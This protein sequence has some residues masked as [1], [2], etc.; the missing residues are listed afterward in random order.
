MKLLNCSLQEAEKKFAN[1]KIIFFGCGSWLQAINYTDLMSLKEQFAYIVDNN[2]H[3]EV[4]LGSM[5]LSVYSPKRIVA[6]QN[7][8]IVLTSPVYMYD[9]YCQLEEMNLSDE[10]ECYAFPFMQMISKQEINESLLNEIL[11]Y[12]KHKIPKIIHSFWFSGDEK[13]AAYQRCVDTWTER[14]EGYEIIEWNKK[15]YDWHKH[16]FVERAV[17]L[18]AWAFASDYARLDVLSQ[19]GGIYLDMDVEVFKSFDSLLGN[20]A[21]LSF[22]NQILVDLAVIGAKKNNI[23]IKQ[24]MELYDTVE[25]PNEKK[26]FAKF[27]QPS[28]VRSVLYNNGIKMNGSLQKINNATVFPSDFFMPQDHILFKEY[29][30]SENTYCIHYDNFGWSF[31]PNNKREKKIRDN[32]ILWRLMETNY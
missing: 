9:M 3:E 11:G 18:G 17:E 10:I 6:E 4:D 29:E 12:K 23:I 8:I 28:F 22:S 26:E 15:N 5:R 20:E 31:S 2:S 30:V 13:P 21:I 14:L 16:P 25:I 19:F 1:R 24:M 27:F 7:C 32:N